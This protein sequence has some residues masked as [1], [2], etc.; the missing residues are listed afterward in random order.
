MISNPQ[1]STA[2]G[3]GTLAF[4]L[5][6]PLAYDPDT[7]LR[8][9][10]LT[11]TAVGEMY[12]NLDFN[13][14]SYLNGDI[15]SVFSGA[16]TTTITAMAYTVQVDQLYLMPQNINGV[17]PYPMI[18]LSTVYELNGNVRS[19]DNLVAGQ[20]KVL[21]YP[22]VRSVIGAYYNYITNATML[23]SHTTRLRT[24]V[25]GNNVMEEWGVNPKILEQRRYTAGDLG[26]G[27]YFN[28]HRM[29]PIETALFGNVVTGFTPAVV[30]TGPN[31]EV[32]YESFYTLGSVL[33]GIN[34]SST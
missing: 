21:P 27:V 32:A 19:T 28:N 29:K 33:P 18:D 13:P 24:I 22:N 3:A 31:V 4:Y 1:I 9:A 20:E 8:G 11:Q 15:E 30:G 16:A 10:I 6:V 7:D 14:S 17:V 34:Q 12:L 5:D 26:A 23:A 2:V 25:N